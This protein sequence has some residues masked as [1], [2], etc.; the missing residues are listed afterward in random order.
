MCLFTFQVLFIMF[1]FL[2][3]LP[4]CTIK[5]LKEIVVDQRK[6][7]VRFHLL[8]DKSYPLLPWLMVPHKQSTLQFF[9]SLI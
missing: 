5:P 6:K 3:F 7:C 8:G 1:K 9:Q 4:T 2:D